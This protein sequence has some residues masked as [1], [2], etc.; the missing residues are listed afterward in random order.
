MASMSR[1]FKYRRLYG[2]FLVCLTLAVVIPGLSGL[3]VVDRDEARFAQASIQMAE[4]NDF[5]NIRFQDEARNKKPAGAYWAQTAMLKLLGNEAKREIWIHRLP[6]LLAALTTVLALYWGGARMIGRDAAFLGTALFAVSMIFVFESHIAKTDALLCAST[7]VMLVSLGRLRLGRGQRD[8]WLFWI[9]LGLSIMIKGPI[10][11]A[12][13]FLSFGSLFLWEKNLAWARP[14]VNWGAIAVF[15]LI[16]LPWGISIYMATDGA[17]F[18][19]SLGQD[20]GQKVAS[21]QEGHGAPPGAHSA[22]IWAMLWPACLF[23][24]P[25]MAYALN[26]GRHGDQARLAKTMRLLLCW[27]VPFWILIELMPTK[28]PHYALPAYPAISLMIGAAITAMARSSVFKKIRLLSGIVFLLATGVLIT[29][30]LYVQTEYGSTNQMSKAIVISIGT[31]ATAITG[32]VSLWVNQNKL[33]FFAA[34]LS[35]LAYCIGTYGFILPTLSDFKAAENIK[36][37]LQNFAPEV[38]D[39]NIHSPHFREP[40]LV[41]HLGGSI[42]V[43]DSAIDLSNGGLVILNTLRE[44]AEAI[45]HKLTQS[46]RTRGKCLETSQRIDG[47]NYSKGVP[48]GLVILREGP[49]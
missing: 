17:F 14:L 26:A 41:Y 6:S 16:W 39:I 19:D 24:I 22:A 31:G 33:A 49:C 23:L 7:T 11:P 15:I 27:A 13:A 34:L 29:A 44:D 28:L 10:G 38:T 35:S 3:P 40:S 18:I 25:G 5:L 37:E 2:F 42:N 4:S 47:F 20:L 1:P 46:A 21:G 12:L 45:G 32:A 9:A 48:I 43:T 30:L 8:V 36:A